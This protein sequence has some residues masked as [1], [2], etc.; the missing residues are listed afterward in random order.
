MR[1]Y[2]VKRAA[3]DEYDLP[4]KIWN[5][6]CGIKGDRPAQESVEHCRGNLRVFGVDE[7]AID[8]SRV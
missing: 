3:S 7:V 4:G 8:L 1:C 5:V 2:G 6:R